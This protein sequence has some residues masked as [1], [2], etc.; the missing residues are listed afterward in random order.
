MDNMQNMPN[1]SSMPG[2]SGMKKNV[3]KCPHHK[4]TPILIILLGVLFLLGALN[5][6]TSSFVMIVWPIILIALGA[7]KL[8]EKTGMCK[9]C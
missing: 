9:C 5:I 6:L 4:V 3:C 1:M 8:A 2:S 7:Q